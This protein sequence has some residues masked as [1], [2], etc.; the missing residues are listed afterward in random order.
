MQHEKKEY[1]IAE[2]VAFAN[3]NSDRHIHQQTYRTVDQFMR[4]QINFEQRKFENRKDAILR[5][6]IR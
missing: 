3:M 1:E 2:A 4:D 6:E 5:E